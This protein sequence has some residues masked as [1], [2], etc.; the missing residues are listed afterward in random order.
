MAYSF[1]QQ[2]YVGKVTAAAPVHIRIEQG[3][4]PAAV[5]DLLEESGLVSSAFLY[6]IY[7]RLDRAYERPKA[8]EYDIRPQTSFRV[9]AQKLAEGP[10]RREVQVTVIE[11]WSV[12]DLIEQLQ[13]I[14]GIDPAAT[15][16]I[17]G[18]SLN[19]KSFDPALRNDFDFLKP[20]PANR[21]LEGYLFPDTYRVWADQLPDALIEKQLEEFQDRFSDAQISSDIAPL[22]TL[23]DVV[24]L[25]SIVQREVRDPEDM[26]IVAGIFLNRL[27]SGMRL[28]SDATVSYLTGSG[29][30]R[31]TPAD[32]Q[33]DSPYNSYRNAGLPPSPIGNPGEQAMRAVLSPE[34]TSYYYFLTDQSGSVLYARTFE[35]HQ[36]NR[37]KA[38]Y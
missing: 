15:A 12:D 5:A 38:G 4:A 23:D 28:Q 22:E 18:Q 6:K 3:L 27:K 7:G 2:A 25:A 21:S 17:A 13:K 14:E 24:I 30:A 26:R 16:S 10:A 1:A 29:R 11:G 20:L 8:G 35:E 36:Q 37:I 9:L 19:R 33:I 31:S 32:L 34:M